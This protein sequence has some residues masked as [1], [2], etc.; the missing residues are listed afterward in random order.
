MTERDFLDAIAKAPDDDLPRLA[1]ADWLEEQHDPRAA[2]VRNKKIWEFMA[3]DASDPVPRMIETA[4]AEGL[5]RVEDAL[6]EMDFSVRA[7]VLLGYIGWKGIGNAEPR[8]RSQTVERVTTALEPWLAKHRRPAWD[9]IVAVGDDTVT[10]SKFC[11]TP[12]I[13]K[14]NPWPACKICHKPLPLFLQLDL[15]HLPAELGSQFGTGL[16][17]LFYCTSC[18][19]VD[20]WDLFGKS[21]S[22]IRIVQPNGPAATTAPHEIGFPAKRITGWTR[23]LDL[24][25]SQ[26]RAA[27][28]LSYECNVSAGTVRVECREL[29]LVFDEKWEL[30]FHEDF[31]LCARGDKLGGWPYWVQN[32]DYPNCPRC[33][34]RMILVFQVGSTDNVPFMFGDSGT[35]HITQCPEHKEVV[36]FGWACC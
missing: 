36:G 27:L 34:R 1:F 4:I 21:W 6:N 31:A 14:D 29:G 9:P 13:G 30:G 2:R 3:P 28:G 11:G 16:L 17:Q 35:G 5:D 24:P 33:D 25:D 32:V 22:C 7:T 10:G 18:E 19:G 12:W 26:E 8:R 15:D 23:F 20:G